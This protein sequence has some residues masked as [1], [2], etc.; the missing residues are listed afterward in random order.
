M[1]ATNTTRSRLGT[2]LVRLTVVGVLLVLVTVSA[3]LVAQHVLAS[4]LERIPDAFAGLRERPGKQENDDGSRAVDVLLVGTSNEAGSNSVPG[5]GWASNTRS[6]TSISVLH[7]DGDR[8]GAAL[9][10]IPADS[11]I[12]S[13]TQAGGRA[14][15]GARTLGAMLSDSRPAQAVRGVEELTGV[16]IDHLM[17]MDWKGYAELTDIVGGVDILVPDSAD[18]SA[19]TQARETLDGKGA[20]AYVGENDL[21][22]GDRA[23]A[24]R[25]QYFL[26]MLM[27]EVL[28]QELR[29]EPFTLYRSLDAAS[30]NLAVEDGWSSGDMRNL[31][32][33]LR[34][35]RAHAINYLSAPMADSDGL[36]DAVRADRHEKWLVDHPAAGLPEVVR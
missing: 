34:H 5:P 13:S 2:V 6:T 17:V 32:V 36:W 7:L 3:G 1:R 33:S 16:R 21:P 28:H 25:E 29:R 11:P 8:R 23:G 9:I 10:S 27:S 31:V 26:Q 4:H 30:R 24:D 35:M 22:G 20:L 15:R 12:A 18:E 14:A 19:S